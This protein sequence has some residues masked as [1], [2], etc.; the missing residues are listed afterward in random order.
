MENPR[1]YLRR[2]TDPFHTAGYGPTFACNIARV[3]SRW[4]LCRSRR[5]TWARRE[6]ESV[7]H[8]PRLIPRRRTASWSRWSQGRRG[9]GRKLRSLNVEKR[10]ATRCN[11]Y[12]YVRGFRSRRRK[13]TPRARARARLATYDAVTLIKRNWTIRNLRASGPMRINV[14]FT[15]RVCV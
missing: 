8:W 11:S 10:Q 5:P 6:G 14:P 9:R 2:T 1:D 7:C 3:A 13:R 15:P 12:V 4:R